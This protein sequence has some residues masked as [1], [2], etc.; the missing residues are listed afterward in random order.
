MADSQLR[1]E[2]G[3]RKELTFATAKILNINKAQKMTQKCKDYAQTEFK[4][5]LTVQ[6]AN[7]NG[8]NGART[9]TWIGAKCVDC[10][11]DMLE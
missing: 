5:T 8:R 1:D 2:F 9:L 11:D 6:K 3:T 10:R 7:P 4:T